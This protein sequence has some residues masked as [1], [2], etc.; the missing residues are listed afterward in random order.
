MRVGLALYVYEYLLHVG[1]QKSA[2]TFLS[3]IR[4][5]KNIT[6][7]EPPGFL[8]SW[9]C[10]FWDLYC[11]AP[12]RREPCEQPSEPKAFQDYSAAAAP[13]PVMGTVPPGEALP[14][15]PIPPAFF[16]LG[17]SGSRP[18]FPLGPG[19]EGPMGG[20]SALEPHHVNGSL[21]AGDVDGLPKKKE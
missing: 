5:E 3:E 2:Q 16:Q 7:G 11:A 20:L 8:H 4:W 12:D 17:P 18:S 13:S 19:P 1:A 14:G 10:V 9:W 6:L 21:G 15:G